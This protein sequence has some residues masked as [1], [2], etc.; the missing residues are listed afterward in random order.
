MADRTP[1]EVLAGLDFTP[2]ITCETPSCDRP[3]RYRLTKTCCGT[4]ALMCGPCTGGS[5]VLLVLVVAS[6]GSACAHCGRPIIDVAQLTTTP[7]KEIPD[8]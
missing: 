7:L 6:G 3:A 4:V 8:A 1:S 5:Q 2:T